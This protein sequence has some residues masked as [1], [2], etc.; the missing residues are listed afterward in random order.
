MPTVSV[1]LNGETKKVSVDE[2]KTLYD[3]LERQGVILPHGCLAGSCGSCKTEILEGEENLAPP[4][5][6]ESN[7]LSSI[8][9][10][11]GPEKLAGR[12]IR[13]SCRAKVKGDVSIRPFKLP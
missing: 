8:K 6:I 11:L 2:G 10:N 12:N 5:A 9:E 13:L 3:E 1:I 7:T 4:S